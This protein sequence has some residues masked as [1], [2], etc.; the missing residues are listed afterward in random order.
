M[1][2][3]EDTMSEEGMETFEVSPEESTT[4]REPV[5]ENRYLHIT[6]VDH[7]PIVDGT[8]E[9]SYVD[10]RIPVGMAEAGLKGVPEGKL[11]SIEP[12]LVLQMVE[13][14]ATGDLVK[15]SEQKKSISIR[16]E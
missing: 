2:P 1:W 12:G 6:I 5:A 11:G 4:R 10:L 3:K 13:I 8:D 9:V 16:I 7:N 14:G 15:I